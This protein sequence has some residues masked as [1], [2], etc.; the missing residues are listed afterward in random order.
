MK[1]S[2]SNHNESHVSSSTYESVHPSIQPAIQPHL[3]LHSSIKRGKIKVGQIN[4][5]ELSPFCVGWL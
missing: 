3:Y 4:K 5:K 2:C 1:L